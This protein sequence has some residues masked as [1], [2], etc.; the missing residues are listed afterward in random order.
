MEKIAIKTDSFSKHSHPWRWILAIAVAATTIISAGIIYQVSPLRWNHQP[1]S[2][3]KAT[4]PPITKVAALGRLEPDSEIIR[5]NAPLPL[6]GDRVEQLLVKEGS[7]VSL[8]QVIAILDSRQRLQSA[9]KQA[10]EQLKVAQARLSQ[11]KAGAKVGE[12]NAQKATVERF[13]ADLSGKIREQKA[14][15]GNLEAQLRGETATQKATITRLQAELENARTECQRYQMLYQDGVVSSSEYNN[16]CL[17]PKTLQESLK[18][19]QA[20]LNRI[21]TTYQQQITEAK[22]NLDRTQATG[23]RQIEQEKATLNQVSEVRPVDIQIAQAEVDNA[24]ANLQQAKTN[25]NQVYIKSPIAGQIIKIHTRVGEKI[26]D[27]GLVELAQTNDMIAVAE[28]YQ[29]DID[30]VK[31]GQKAV[32]TSQAFPGQLKGNVSQIGL[33][34]NRQNVFSSQPGENL[35]RRVIEVKIR[36]NSQASKRVAGLTNLQVQVEIEINNH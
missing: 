12:I 15:I 33:Q 23:I 29:T 26:G 7:K 34:V 14:A 8:G 24:W 17:Q 21:I 9:V 18:E 20:N 5:L 2:E 35:D 13:K 36:L 6:D 28:V 3:S 1:P 10:Q 30:K 19:A 32:I 16:K 11:V 25:L 27:A 31:L 22:A 4:T